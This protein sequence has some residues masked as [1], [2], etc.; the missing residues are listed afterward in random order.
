MCV[1]AKK[2]ERSLFIVKSSAELEGQG[3]G[4]VHEHFHS[5]HSWLW[6]W[7]MRF[8]LGLISWLYSVRSVLGRGRWPGVLLWS[9]SGQAFLQLWWMRWWISGSAEVLWH[10]F[11]SKDA[12]A[13]CLTLCFLR[14]CGTMGC[15]EEEVATT[16][17][18]CV[19]WSKY[20]VGRHF[21][22]KYRD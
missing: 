19:S 3:S 21:Y 6:W 18:A 17:G 8:M 11:L 14:R 15:I 4:A 9:A 5:R 7:W 20:A 22:P 13:I 2:R 1:S 10:Q 12:D 16:A